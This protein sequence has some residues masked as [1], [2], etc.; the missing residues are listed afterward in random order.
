MR[1]VTVPWRNLRAIS[2]AREDAKG[3]SASA[4][5]IRADIPRAAEGR[6]R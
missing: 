1:K 4:A 3:I 5:A 6:R 2:S